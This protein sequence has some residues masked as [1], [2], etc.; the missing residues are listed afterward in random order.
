[1][2]FNITFNNVSVISWQSVLLMQETGILGEYH[3]HATRHGQ[4]LS[5]K[6]ASSTSRLEW[7]S[8]SQL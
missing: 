6:V 8:N 1:M 5:Q 2:V 7:D 3:R 4:I